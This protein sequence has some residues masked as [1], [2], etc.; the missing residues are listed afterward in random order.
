MAWVRAVIPVEGT[1][2]DRLS[3][4]LLAAGALS[5]SIEDA[6]GGAFDENPIYAEPGEVNSALWSD[7]VVVALFQPT[8]AVDQLIESAAHSVAMAPPSNVRLDK[9]EEQDWVRITQQ[10]FAP[11]QVSRRLWIVPSWSVAPD[12]AAINLHLDPGQ[13]FGTGSHPTTQLCLRWLDENVRGGETVMDYGCGSGILAIAAVKLGAA[14]ACGT[15]ID[16]IAVQVAQD[17]ARANHVAIEFRIPDSLPVIEADVTIANILANPLK[18]LAPLLT[19]L[20]R[21]G[22]AL[23]LSGILE[24]QAQDMIEC[25]RPGVELEVWAKEEGWV[26]LAGTRRR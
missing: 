3:D 1:L 16:P 25:Y 20:T 5:A 15:D 23:I 26:A 6:K 11:I 7:C 10:Q 4:A 21:P 12:P 22:G 19:G 9:V 14:R 17:N 2:A 18:V 8:V 24:E 13:A